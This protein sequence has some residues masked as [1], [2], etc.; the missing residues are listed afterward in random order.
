FADRNAQLFGLR[1]LQFIQNETVQHLAVECGRGREICTAL[2]QRCNNF[3]GFSVQFALYNHVFV[4]DRDDPVKRFDC[5]LQLYWL[6]QEKHQKHG[7]QCRP[8]VR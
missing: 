3:R 6:H 2:P 8:A 1:K 4:D 7:Q 5:R